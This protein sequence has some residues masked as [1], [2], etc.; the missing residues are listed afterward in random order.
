LKNFEFV[1]ATGPLI[2]SLTTS[3]II[4]DAETGK[5]ISDILVLLHPKGSDSLIYKDKPYY[6]SRTEENGSFNIKHLKEGTYQ[7]FALEDQNFNYIYDLPNERIGFLDSNVV[8][9]TI[10]VNIELDAF[11]SIKTQQKLISAKVKRTGK[12][13]VIFSN[14]I[15][16]ALLTSKPEGL[17]EWNESNDTATIWIQ[18]VFLNTLT[19]EFQTDTGNDIRVLALKNIPED[20]VFQKNRVKI[21]SSLKTVSTRGDQVSTVLPKHPLGKPFKLIF[22][23]PLASINYD[24]IQIFEDSTSNEVNYKSIKSVNTIDRIYS[25]EYE[26]KP[27]TKYIIS[28]AKRCVTDF[29][30]LVNDSTHFEFETRSLAEYGNINFELNIDTSNSYVFEILDPA[31]ISV[32][33][34]ILNEISR[35]TFKVNFFKVGNYTAKITLDENGNGKWDPGDYSTKKQSEKYLLFEEPIQLRGEWELDFTWNPVFV[36]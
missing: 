22:S 21:S 6:F 35:K 8:I 2:D 24:K 10:P 5:P 19:V 18:N 36:K 27:E 34:S 4:R 7:V 16:N 31:G 28:I 32:F 12:A 17:Y 20:S 15:N 23:N 13:E 1:F 9:D 26:W 29:F 11:T 33:T 30:Q 14:T 25:I 3:G